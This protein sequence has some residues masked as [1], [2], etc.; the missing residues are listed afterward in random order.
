MLLQFGV[1]PKYIDSVELNGQISTIQLAELRSN[2]IPFRFS[3][4]YE[5]I[6]TSNGRVAYYFWEEDPDGTFMVNPENPMD[7]FT[8]PFKQNHF[9]VYFLVSIKMIINMMMIKK[10]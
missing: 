9:Y 10:Y 6:Q 5:N 4:D 1:S 7:S 2:L 3:D 8:H